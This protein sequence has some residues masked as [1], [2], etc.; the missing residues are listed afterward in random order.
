MLEDFSTR[1]DF[2]ILPLFSLPRRSRII[3]LPSIDS[4]R[5]E[6]LDHGHVVAQ[7]GREASEGSLGIQEETKE[8]E[9]AKDQAEGQGVRRAGAAVPQEEGLQEHRAEAARGGHDRRRRLHLDRAG[10]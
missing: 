8:E 9:E 6:S 3:D 5:L 10:E 2:A 4:N 7:Q 1:Y